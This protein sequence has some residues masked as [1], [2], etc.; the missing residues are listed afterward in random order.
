MQFTHAYC[1]AGNK[2][3][4][5]QKGLHNK[6]TVKLKNEQKKFVDKVKE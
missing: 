5:M 3:N 6:V 1:T 2:L 4:M